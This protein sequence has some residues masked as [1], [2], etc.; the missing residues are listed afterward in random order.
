MW[1]LEDF[2]E[3]TFVFGVGERLLQIDHNVVV[4]LVVVVDSI[5]FSISFLYLE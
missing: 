3:E 4:A 5:C 2:F 1:R